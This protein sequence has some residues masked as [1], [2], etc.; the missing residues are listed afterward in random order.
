MKHLY[1]NYDGLV[2]HL[3]DDGKDRVDALGCVHEALIQIFLRMEG[4]GLNQ[5]EL[6]RKVGVKR[7]QLNRWF[8]GD[9]GINAK[10][11]FALAHAVDLDINLVPRFQVV[12]GRET[13]I[14]TRT[15][16]DDQDDQDSMEC[17][18]P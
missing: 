7:Q 4:L 1:T 17:L 13:A 12:F 14:E 15:A 16:R 18:P 11:L 8:A 9:G 10:S 5:A 2:S 3:D 6:A